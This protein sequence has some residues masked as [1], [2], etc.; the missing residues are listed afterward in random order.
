MTYYYGMRMRG[1]APLCQPKDFTERLDD[2]SG[3]YHDILA[4][5]RQLTDNELYEY[6]L[7]YL[8]T[9]LY[10]ASINVLTNEE[11]Q[12]MSTWDKFSPEQRKHAARYQTEW[13]KKNTTRVSIKLVNTTD[14]DILAWLD[15]Q[16][17]KQGYIKSLI[18]A[19]IAAHADDDTPDDIS[20]TGTFENGVHTLRRK[21]N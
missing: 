9:T 20:Y 7:D 14:A 16:P 2:T 5:T 15:A 21:E 3:R 10:N 19:D 4:Y 11:E 17:N 6:E 12:N 18:R 1:C 13:D 8:G